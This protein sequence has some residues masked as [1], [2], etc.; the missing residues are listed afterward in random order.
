[1]KLYQKMLLELNTPPVIS[2][3]EIIIERVRSPKPNPKFEKWF[4][5]GKGALVAASIPVPIPG[6]TPIIAYLM[7]IFDI[8]TFKCLSKCLKDNTSKDKKVCT[9]QCKYDASEW[10]V[11]HIQDQIK[12]LRYIKD[13]KKRKKV[14]K[15]LYDMLSTWR[16]TS[17]ENKIALRTLIKHSKAWSKGGTW[18]WDE[19]F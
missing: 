6:T 9:A 7:H 8:T 17:V 19:D 10:V 5:N 16:K 13:P 14:E 1:V 18:S 15:S 3:E 2:E 12:H 4:K 11:N